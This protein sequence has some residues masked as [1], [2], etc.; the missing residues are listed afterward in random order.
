[1]A[2]DSKIS[3]VPYI[4]SF[5]ILCF[6]AFIPLHASTEAMNK[7]S[8]SS[9]CLSVRALMIH[10]RSIK[11]YDFLAR[12]INLSA[13]SNFN[14]IIIEATGWI[15]YPSLVRS[16]LPNAF[17]PQTIGGLAELARSQ[18]LEVIPYVQLLTHQ[19]EVLKRYQPE[20]LLNEATADIGNPKTW[21]F[22]KK[23]LDDSIAMFHPAKMLI[24]HDELTGYG[25]K[26]SSEKRSAGA[27]SYAMHIIRIHDYLKR[28]GIQTII[29]GDMFL[30]P[31]MSGGVYPA[32]GSK[33]SPGYNGS[34]EFVR[35][36]RTLPRDIVIADWH[37]E[38]GT[39]LYPSFDFFQE[40]GF[41]VWGASWH[42]SHN[43]RSF[44][45]YVQNRART[46]EGMIAT[47]WH[48]CEEKY[49]DYLNR[50]IVESGKSLSQGCNK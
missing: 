18:G 25:S 36:L 3:F 32:D 22:E 41:T 27:R 8:Q 44:S 40:Q 1:M 39:D 30:T 2:I 45:H 19:Q 26:Q 48:F 17:N 14:S 10:P 21:E 37:Y 28:M 47:T 46:G 9:V 31:E 16:G 43:I 12:L 38:N 15:N 6:S 34:P 35:V 33:A 11:Q 5:T 42:E 13:K 29:W 7:D 50:I 23:L 20:L 4:K 24:G 49:S